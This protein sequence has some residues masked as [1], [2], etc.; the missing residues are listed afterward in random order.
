MIKGRFGDTS[1]RPY[2]EGRLSI[3][4]QKLNTDVS[5]VFDTGADRTTLM[6]MDGS[7]L[8]INY[9][10]LNWVGQSTGVGGNSRCCF[11]AAIVTFRDVD[12]S[13]YSFK[14]D[15]LIIEPS[16][17][18]ATVPALLGRDIINRWR[19][20]YDPIFDL[21][22]CEVQSVDQVFGAAASKFKNGLRVN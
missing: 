22:E 5:F 2:I 17:E 6:P 20:N 12:G 13:L 9:K 3:P 21:I 1:K 19:T 10:A 7:K 15:L 4:T 14:I 16:P 18:I 8:G 11:E